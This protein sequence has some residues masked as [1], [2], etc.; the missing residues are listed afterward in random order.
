MHK[1]GETV[2]ANIISK[3]MTKLRNNEF[4]WMKEVTCQAS[5]YTV[6]ENVKSAFENF[7]KK[8][9]KYPTFKKKGV[10]EAFGFPN[11]NGDFRT[12][13]DRVRIPKL[14][15]VKMACPLRYEGRL[16]KGTVSRKCGKWYISIS[17]EF[18]DMPPMHSTET[19]SDAV[20]VDLGVK[21]LAVLSNGVVYGDDKTFTNYKR[22]LRH[23]Q[24]AMSRRRGA[25]KGEAKSKRFLKAKVKVQKL[26][27]S[28]ANVRNQQLHG[29]TAYLTRSFGTIGIEDL[30][31]SGMLKNHK[32]AGAIQDKSFFEFRRQLD[33]KAKETGST[34]V[35]ADMFFASSKTCNVCGFKNEELQLKDRRWICNNCGTEHDRDLNAAINLRNNAVGLTV[36][37][38]GEFLRS[39]APL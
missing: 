18:P 9:G 22:R 21:S 38:R 13:G 36:S 30:N 11:A 31:V 20:G 23:A 2:N 1:N 17:V 14:G 19:P 3:M 39:K 29:L 32:L 37:A 35:V 27:A 25:K 24:K 4:K 33:Y 6:H 16:V 10:H 28:R 15:Y 8:R 26:M 34:V 12:D 5:H 7:F